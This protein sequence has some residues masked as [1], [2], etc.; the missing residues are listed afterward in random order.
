MIF[1]VKSFCCLEDMNLMTFNEDH[2]N[3]VVDFDVVNLLD[4]VDLTTVMQG[5][6]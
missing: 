1:Y 5:R 6:N 2:G 3:D 4:E